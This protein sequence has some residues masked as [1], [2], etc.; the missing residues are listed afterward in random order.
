MPP[1]KRIQDGDVDSKGRITDEKTREKGRIASAKYYAKHPEA[2][3]KQRIRMAEKRAAIK[4][5]RRQWDPPK[6]PKSGLQDEHTVS[7][8]NVALPTVSPA[9]PVPAPT[10]PRKRRREMDSDRK[11]D[12]KEEGPSELQDECSLSNES[13]GETM[14]PSSKVDSDGDYDAKSTG[15]RKERARKASA[16][17]Y[18]LHPEI[19][20]TKRI[21]MAEKRAEIKARRRRWDPPKKSKSGGQDDPPSSGADAAPN[22]AVSQTSMRLHKRKPKAKKMQDRGYVSGDDSGS[23]KSSRASTPS[24]GADQDGEYDPK[25]QRDERARK[26]HR[27]ASAKY[28]A[29]HPE[30]REKQRIRMAEKRAAIKARRRKWDPPKKPKPNLVQDIVLDEGTA[31]SSATPDD[32]VSSPFVQLRESEI[33]LDE[34]YDDKLMLDDHLHSEDGVLSGAS[35]PRGLMDST[36]S[37]TAALSMGGVYSWND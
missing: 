21:K 36:L 2:R 33:G 25:L 28:Y 37:P 30:A 1:R 13:E 14:P 11:H 9:G 8:D 12:S 6:N 19:R 24:V 34:E 5:K 23:T 32:N 17:Y 31:S 10:P 15:D 29:K 20:E 26:S 3:E 35:T 22:E 18:A 16:K 4:A 7:G 27:K